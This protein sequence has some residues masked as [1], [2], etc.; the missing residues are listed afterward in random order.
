M[1]ENHKLLGGAVICIVLFLILS[2]IFADFLFL[3]VPLSFL[4]SWLFQVLLVLL[5]FKLWFKEEKPS[6]RL[7]LK[8]LK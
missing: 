1:R 5:T 2:S 8:L 7:T 4:A 3:S 6:Q